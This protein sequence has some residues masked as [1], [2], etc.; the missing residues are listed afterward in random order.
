M[1][2]FYLTTYGRLWN[3]RAPLGGQFWSAHKRS[4]KSRLNTRAEAYANTLKIGVTIHVLEE[5][6][7]TFQ[8]AKGSIFIRLPNLLR[9]MLT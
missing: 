3:S 8:L 5:E 9:W 7:R 2:Q 1:N 6:V 4:T